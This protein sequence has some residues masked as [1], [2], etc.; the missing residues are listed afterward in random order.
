MSQPGSPRARSHL[1]LRRLEGLKE[2]LGQPGVVLVNVPAQ[3]ERVHD[4]EQARAAKIVLLGGAEI[5]EEPLHARVS[6]LEGGRGMRAE[7][8]V[9]LSLAKRPVQGVVFGNRLQTDRGG[10]VEGDALLPS[11]NFLASGH[12]GDVFRRDAVFVVEQPPHPDAGRHGVFGNPD[13]PPFQ[14]F[15]APDP[16]FGADEDPR[17]PEDPGRKEPECR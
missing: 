1:P 4:G 11:G 9:H 8:G 13:A 5:G 17:V 12:P 16:V 14:V 10:E 6:G 3:D 7:Q 15:R 2:A